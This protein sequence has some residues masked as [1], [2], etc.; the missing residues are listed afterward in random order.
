MTTT[1]ADVDTITAEQW[2]EAKRTFEES[3]PEENGMTVEKYNSIVHLLESWDQLTIAERREQSGGNHIYWKNKYKVTEAQ[4]VKDLLILEA[5]GST[6][7]CSHRGRMFDDIKAVH[8][9]SECIT[10]FT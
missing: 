3:L 5:D 2:E 4:G 6:K 1:S 10:A 7:I 9:E 8:I